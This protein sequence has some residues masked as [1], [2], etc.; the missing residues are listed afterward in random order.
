MV[1]LRGFEPR[2]HAPK[3]WM[4]PDYT[5]ERYL[6]LHDGYDPPTNAYKALVLPIKLMEQ[7]FK[8]LLMDYKLLLMKVLQQT[9]FDLQYMPAIF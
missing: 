9:S 5:T 6:E 7:I 2:T 4:L 3:A 8:L 1:S